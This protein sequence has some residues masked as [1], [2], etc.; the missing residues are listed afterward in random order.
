MLTRPRIWCFALA[1][2]MAMAVY[3]P[4]LIEVSRPAWENGQ[5]ESLPGMRHEIQYWFLLDRGMRIEDGGT[6]L[7]VRYAWQQFAVQ[8]GALALITL[9]L[10]RATPRP[11]D[12]EAGGDD[13][14]R[15]PKPDPA[16]FEPAPE[17]LVA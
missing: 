2:G 6:A 12:D 10:L 15:P 8:M 9:M 3:P 1:V 7:W 4:A 13:G 16:P 14:G 11:P 5:N 17:A